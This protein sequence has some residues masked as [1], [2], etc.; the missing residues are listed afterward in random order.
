MKNTQAID[1]L[2]E[3]VKGDL[4]SLSHNAMI[5]VDGNYELFNYYTVVKN[6]N[7]TC[8][9]TKYLRDSRK[10]SSIQPAVAWCIADKLQRFDTAR[11]I[12]DLDQQCNAIRNDV[13][14][15]QKM[16][17]RITDSSRQE[18]VIA[19]LIHKQSNLKAMEN[20]LTKC[21]NL[22]KYWQ[23]KGFIRDETARPRNPTPTR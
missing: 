8:T 18:I 16:T 1:R 5:K 21:I 13:A 3:I 6:A 20:Q 14:I 19:K 2:A 22:A 11:Q 17:S 10:F 15:T 23:I 9:V 7:K 12:S 4:E